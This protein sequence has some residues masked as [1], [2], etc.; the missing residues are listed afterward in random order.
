MIDRIRM[1]PR[2]FRIVYGD[3]RRAALQRFPYPIT[4]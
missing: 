3:I 1:S 4:V 2:L